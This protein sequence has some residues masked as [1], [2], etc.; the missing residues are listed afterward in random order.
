MNLS[1]LVVEDDPTNRKWIQHLLKL[2]GLDV[3]AVVSAEEALASLAKRDFD[4]LIVDWILPKMD[5]LT[6]TRL[7]RQTHPDVIILVVTGRTEA[8]ALEQVMASGASDYLGKPF[9]APALY[10]RMA[11]SEARVM[12]RRSRQ[13]AEQQVETIVEGMPDAVVFWDT[14]GKIRRVNDSFTRMT[15]LQK[16]DCIGQSKGMIYL[17]PKEWEEDRRRFK[18][19][20]SGLYERSY[21]RADGN[22]FLAESSTG[23]VTSPR[24]QLGW[25][26]IFRDISRR[27]EMS[28]RLRMTDRLAQIGLLSAGVAHEINNP[29]TFVLINLNVLSQELGDLDPD[30][31]DPVLQD[32]LTVVADA[33]EGCQRVSEI[34]KALRTFARGDDHRPEKVLISELVSN[35]LVVLNASLRRRAQVVTH[36]EASPT[37]LA[38][39][40]DLA[41]V[42]I[43]LI[44]NAEETIP[45]DQKGTITIHV[46]TQDGQALLEVRD[47]GPGIPKNVKARM[48]DAFYSTKAGRS[49]GLGLATSQSIVTRL[50]GVITCESHMGMGTT[51]RVLLPPG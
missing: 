12:E 32:L 6:L 3:E 30:Q 24:G 22:S 18:D 1:C 20:D 17:S 9:T 47:E 46:G 27:V 5:G 35:A 49:T 28:E 45:L 43:N 10:A 50:G 7:V 19:Q 25:V 39:P 36:F 37:V 34:I 23:P 2:R 29:L 15:G 11:V 16:Q 13:Q 41:Q 51:F 31:K 44:K 21:K 26:T 40:G 33:E 48:F 8:G 14:E 4:L 42:I 38:P